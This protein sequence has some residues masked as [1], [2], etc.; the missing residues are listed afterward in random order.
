MNSLLSSS[1]CTFHVCSSSSTWRY[2]NY[3]QSRT[4]SQVTSN[5]TSMN[6]IYSRF[7]DILT[8][9]DVNIDNSSKLNVNDDIGMDVEEGNN[10]ENDID[11]DCDNEN[12]NEIDNES[13]WRTVP[14]VNEIISQD[15]LSNEP[16][17]QDSET[18]TNN[19][20]SCNERSQS[21]TTNSLP[22]IIKTDSSYNLTI[23]RE[24]LSI[25]IKP[26]LTQIKGVISTAIDIY[27]LKKS[28]ENIQIQS[29]N[30][31]EENYSNDGTNSSS[32]SN[33]SPS[34]SSPSLVSN[35]QIDIDE[36]VLVGGSSLIPSIQ[37]TIRE[38]LNEKLIPSFSNS[39]NK[40][41]CSSICPYECVVNGLAIKGGLLSGVQSTILQD[42]LMIDV[43]PSTIGIL[44]WEIDSNDLN[45]FTPKFEPFIPRGTSLPCKIRKVYEVDEKCVE[46]GLLTLQLYEEIYPTSNE[47]KNPLAFLS[48]SSINEN[49]LCEEQN[50]LPDST[51]PTPISSDSTLSQIGR[52]Q[53]IEILGSFELA[54]SECIYEKKSFKINNQDF[55]DNNSNGNSNDDDDEITGDE[56]DHTMISQW[57]VDIE[58]SINTEGILNYKVCPPPIKEK[59]TDKDNNNLVEKK[60]KS[61]SD[62]NSSLILLY[63]YIFFLF[64]IYIFVKIQLSSP[65]TSD[66]PTTPSHSSTVDSLMK[67]E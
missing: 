41:F 31:I 60:K 19:S 7:S 26:L 36:V 67:E 3:S 38:I 27:I 13:T 64:I 48:S 43:T 37:Q 50:N 44:V 21:T 29:Q 59:Q 16:S 14:D 28:R 53:P 61:N 23:T 18:R 6:D 33:P 35:Q 1:L 32:S 42:I 25:L 34:S 45:E 40:E 15:K 51:S 22:Q 56:I 62:G 8:E 63:F 58:L 10:N 11:G 9:I 46:S 5:H 57:F 2:S 20:T 52:G 4:S 65:L 30:N 66:S 24:L 49:Y 47:V 54:I 55:D 17:L 39:S 12:E